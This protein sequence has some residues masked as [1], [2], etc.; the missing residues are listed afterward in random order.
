MILKRN[1]NFLATTLSTAVYRRVW[2][3]ALDKL[4]D[5]LWSSILMAQ[6]FTTLGAA[7]FM[8]DLETITSVI[9]QHILDGSAALG[10]LLDGAMLLNLPLEASG[11]EISLQQASDRIFTDNTEAKKLLAELGLGSLTPANARKILQRRV[12]NSE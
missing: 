4:Q 8:R 2:R 1:L 5:I 6:S 7:Q 11:E 10:A 12:E 3:E 9:D